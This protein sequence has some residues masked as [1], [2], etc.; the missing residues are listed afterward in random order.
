M[1][2]TGAPISQLPAA[3]NTTGV[4]DDPVQSSTDNTPDDFFRLQP[5]PD[6]PEMTTPFP[7]DDYISDSIPSFNEYVL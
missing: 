2:T 3:Q 7:Y 5:L 4:S 6:V 1:H